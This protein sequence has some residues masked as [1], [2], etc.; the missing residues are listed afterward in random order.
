MSADVLTVVGKN[1]IK[2]ARPTP[3]IIPRTKPAGRLIIHLGELLS[4]GRTA[5]LA[6]LTRTNSGLSS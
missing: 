5:L 3:S 4:N 2:K 6:M 1:S